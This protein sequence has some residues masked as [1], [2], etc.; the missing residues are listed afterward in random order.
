MLELD[1][2]IEALKEQVAEFEGLGLVYLKDAIES[3]EW[4]RDVRYWDLVEDD[5]M[6]DE[7]QRF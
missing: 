2:I 1:E 3:I 4:A 5:L 7:E 6:S